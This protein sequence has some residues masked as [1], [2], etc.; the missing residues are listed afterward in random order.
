MFYAGNDASAKR[1]THDLATALG[2]DAVDAG[3]L[4]QARLLEQL[5]VL[6]ISLAYGA[7]GAPA[8]GREFAFR[9]VRR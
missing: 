8:L 6:W 3:N 4:V 7:G 2:F 1:A 9:L 5:A